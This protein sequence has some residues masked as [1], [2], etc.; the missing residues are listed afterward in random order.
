MKCEDKALSRFWK[1]EI[2]A[3]I[4]LKSDIRSFLS[5]TVKQRSQKIEKS[6]KIHYLINTDENQSGS[7]IQSGPYKVLTNILRMISK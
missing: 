2:C 6:A 7:T 3:L 5:S 4:D 1:M